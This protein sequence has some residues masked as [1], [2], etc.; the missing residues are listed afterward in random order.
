M[1]W[2]E[3]RG[4]VEK[5]IDFIVGAGVDFWGGGWYSIG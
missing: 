4:I 1:A 5:G 2:L 3:S